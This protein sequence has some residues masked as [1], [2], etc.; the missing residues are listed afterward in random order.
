MLLNLREMGLLA[1]FPA[2]AMAGEAQ[3]LLSP[4]RHLLPGELPPTIV[5]RTDRSEVAAALAVAN[6]AYGHPRAEELAAKLADPATAIVITGQQPGLFG[7]PLYTFSKIIAAARWAHLLESRGQPAVAAFWVATEDH[8]FAEVAAGTFLGSAGPHRF[9]LGDDSQPLLPVGMRSL[10][11]EVNR[12]LEKLREQQ[13]APRFQ[14]WLTTL[15]HW[16]RPNA[17]FGEAFSRLMVHLLGERCPLMVDSLLPSL[18]RAQAPWMAKLVRHREDLEAAAR[19]ADEAIVAA[20]Y[21]LQVSPQPGSSPLFLLR[22][23]QR[24]RI[25]W[26]GPGGY[27]LR[28]DDG[29]VREVEE[30]LGIL[31]ENPG[32]VSPGVLARP[33]IQDAVFGTTLQVL[34]PG[35]L[36]YMPQ[37]AATYRVLGIPAPHSVLRPQ[38]LV[39]EPRHEEWLED[40]GLSLEE[41]LGDERELEKLLAQRAG[42]D[43]VTP[44]AQR[45]AELLGQ[46]EEPVMAVDAN[47]Q[48]PFSKTR[49]QIGRALDQLAGRVAA[50]AS[51]ADEIQRRRLD[52]IRG[53]SRP[54][55]KLQERVVSTSFFP[56]KYGSGLTDAYWQQMV[57]DP[58][59]LQ[60]IRPVPSSQLEG[61]S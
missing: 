35:E 21:S 9:G 30:L 24:R 18:K 41:V 60:V 29:S 34:G 17:R 8:D 5:G 50:S 33:A 13:K 45:V 23:E 25:E 49:D 19:G 32:I 31:E 61:Q 6:Q 46:L 16:Y 58:C 47:L 36:S 15:S 7:G 56:G 22:G 55:G 59:D 48:K 51:R 12:V 20:G 14:E 54:G 39:L 1:G 27:G 44:V 57:L 53:T 52:S 28:G 43:V 3:E 26:R 38:T 11:E 40:L 2:A 42:A 10:G 37:A 4:L